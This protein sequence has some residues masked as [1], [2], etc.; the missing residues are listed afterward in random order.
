MAQ[1]APDD[2]RFSDDDLWAKPEG[3]GVRIG[4]TDFA[5]D[6]LGEIVYVGAP[7]VGE[8]VTSG[9]AMGEVESTKTV[10]DLVAPISGRVIRRNEEL[11]DR[12]ELLN[13]S[14]YDKGWIALVEPQGDEVLETLMTAEEYREARS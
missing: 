3:D 4:V 6:Q 7:A 8:T 5:Q 11:D 1:S 12:P 13:S 10:S 9:Q 14:P 2:R